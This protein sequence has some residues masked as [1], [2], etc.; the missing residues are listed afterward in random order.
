MK[1]TGPFDGDSKTWMTRPR[2][3]MVAV[4]LIVSGVIISIMMYK[5]LATTALDDALIRSRLWWEIVL[6]VQ[7]LSAGVVWFSHADAIGTTSGARK[8]AY[9]IQC[10]YTTMAVLLPTIMGFLSIWFNWFEVRPTNT[11]YWT[12]YGLGVGFWS[13]GP[14]IRLINSF[15]KNIPQA[16]KWRPLGI[17]DAIPVL[18]LVMIAAYGLLFGDGRTW[19]AA[20]P[21]ALY[22]QSAVPFIFK[23]FGW[24]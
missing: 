18:S 19:S 2:A 8:R 9:I 24:R 11:A 20:T 1:K 12:A 22:C 16:K 17:W 21:I 23:G 15:A 10:S 14:A 6:N 3:L 4:A 13:I 7:I 5:Y